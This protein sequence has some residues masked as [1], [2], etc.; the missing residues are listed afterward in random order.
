MNE[1]EIYNHILSNQDPG[2]QKFIDEILNLAKMLNIQ[3]L[4]TP[5]QILFLFQKSYEELFFIKYELTIR[6]IEPIDLF[7]NFK[8]ISII[9]PHRNNI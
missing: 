6:S 9:Y 4:N 8:T 5:Q 2:K 1:E 7:I 3:I